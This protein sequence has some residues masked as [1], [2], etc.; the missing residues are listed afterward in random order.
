MAASVAVLMFLLLPGGTISASEA[1]D[2]SM[3]AERRPGGVSR[4]LVYQ[5]IRVESSVG[6]AQCEVWSALN[7]ERVQ[8]RW[9][10]QQEVGKGL[11]DLYRTNRF[12]PAIPISASNHSRWRKA[13]APTEDN[14]TLNRTQ[15]LLTVSTRRLGRAQTGDILEA[16]LVVRQSDWRAVEQDFHVQA[17]QG[18]REYHLKE[19]NHR[20]EPFSSEAWDRI[21]PASPPP[22]AAVAAS[23]PAPTFTASEPEARVDLDAAEVR[24]LEALRRSNFDIGA[25]IEIRRTRNALEVEILACPP[26]QCSVIGPALAGISAVQVLFPV[27]SPQQAA[28]KEVRSGSGTP[29]PPLLLKQ[30]VEDLGSE[31]AAEEL[32]A[33]INNE[34]ALARAHAL[35]LVRLRARALDPSHAWLDRP[36]LREAVERLAR[37]HVSGIGNAI[38]RIE[39]LV[40]PVTDSPPATVGAR[41][42]NL[43]D[44]ALAPL[45]EQ[46]SE[47]QGISDRL[48]AVTMSGG[49][50]MDA[51]A[52]RLKAKLAS[53]RTSVAGCLE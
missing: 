15:G 29:V 48:F 33:R 11:A 2:R 23:A 20:V 31:Q 22:A 40:K 45:S 27:T 13:A 7:G 3:E 6:S 26:E 24:V 50:Q 5:K 16:T 28:T 10:G 43:W 21:L 38:L 12:N 36:D 34:F 17:E 32:V 47:A 44:A 49:G 52:D 4:P 25:D 19:I 42:C 9:T 39:L 14:V 46:I 35:A 41:P 51:S 8:D 1:L 18:Y 53:I 30:L 37:D